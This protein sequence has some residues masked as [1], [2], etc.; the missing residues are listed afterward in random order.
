MKD[1]KLIQICQEKLNKSNEILSILLT[2]INRLS[3]GDE[4][5][6]HKCFVEGQLYEDYCR[7]VVV[8]TN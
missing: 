5:H 8:E 3:L 6:R 7:I 1:P 2:E 4:F